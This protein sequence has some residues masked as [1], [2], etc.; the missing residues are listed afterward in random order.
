MCHPLGM[1]DPG[2]LP[3]LPGQD[4]ATPPPC[5][6]QVVCSG[7]RA[8]DKGTT[9]RTGWVWGFLETLGEGDMCVLETEFGAEMLGS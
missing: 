8:R 1:G 3:S 5:P 9:S 6:L 7:Q 4:R 2:A